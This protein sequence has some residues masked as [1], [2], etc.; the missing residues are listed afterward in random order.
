MALKRRPS[1]DP[2]AFLAKVGEGR[3]INTYHKG[4]NVQAA[5]A[6]AIAAREAVLDRLQWQIAELRASLGKIA[7]AHEAMAAEL[8]PAERVLRW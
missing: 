3:S 5:L 6:Q 8:V 4:R 1:F 2:K 7:V